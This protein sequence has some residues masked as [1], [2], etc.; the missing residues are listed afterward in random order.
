MNHENKFD[1]LPIQEK[2]RTFY[3]YLSIKKE[4]GLEALYSSQQ[5]LTNLISSYAEAMVV[6]APVSEDG[7]WVIRSYFV[8]KPGSMD[9]WDKLK[10][11]LSAGRLA[12]TN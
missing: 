3:H 2:G 10:W 8:I 1:Q 7:Y 6:Y 11:P 4:E 9:D 12:P 5:A